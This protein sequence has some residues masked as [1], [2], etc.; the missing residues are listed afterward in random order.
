[1]AIANIVGLTLDNAITKAGASYS[2][3]NPAAT[4]VTNS[5]GEGTT[6]YTLP[7]FAFNTGGVIPAGS[8]INSATLTLRLTA[9]FAGE[10]TA[11]FDKHLVVAVQK[12]FL[13]FGA[14]VNA[15]AGDYDWAASNLMQDYLVTEA[16]GTK[17]FVLPAAAFS[18]IAT[19]ADIDVPDTNPEKNGWTE[20]SIIDQSDTTTGFLVLIWT[21]AA[22]D[23]LRTSKA[24]RTRS[25]RA[26]SPGSAGVTSSPAPCGLAS[27]SCW[28]R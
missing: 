16:L 14:V 8:T 19:A 6:D 17:T 26:S 11:V 1:M 27:S 9:W 10:P 3:G 18:R 13:A 2:I 4:T 7:M 21:W 28:K 5:R 15:V 20:V 22:A 23:P 12:D 24:S 25:S